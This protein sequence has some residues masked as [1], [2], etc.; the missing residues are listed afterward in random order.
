VNCS[1]L[2]AAIFSG[3]VFIVAL[4]IFMG[5][6]T[7]SV[8]MY[9]YSFALMWCAI[10]PAVAAGVGF[11]LLKVNLILLFSSERS[12]RDSRDKMFFNVVKCFYLQ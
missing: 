10:V 8:V 7:P 5:Q 1:V 4:G 11:L 6:H 9:G 2:I 12:L 3:A